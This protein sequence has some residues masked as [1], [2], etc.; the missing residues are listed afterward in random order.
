MYHKTNEDVLSK[1]VLQTCNLFSFMDTNSLMKFSDQLTDEEY[2]LF[3]Y[4]AYQGC[5]ITEAANKIE[6]SLSK[7]YKLLGAIKCKG[8]LFFTSNQNI[9]SSKDRNINLSGTYTNALHADIQNAPEK[10]AVSA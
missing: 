3:D 7:T 5:T 6:F 4:M 1:Y 9:F 2:L 8:M 10:F